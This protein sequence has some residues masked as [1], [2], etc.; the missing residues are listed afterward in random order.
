MNLLERVWITTAEVKVQP[1]DMSSGDC[2][3]FMKIIMWAASQEDFVRKLETYLAR[4]QWVLLSVEDTSVVDSSR[5]Y[6]DEVNQMIEE[7]L[8]DH[9]A[10]RLGTYYSY[11]AN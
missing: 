5:D 7:A 11:K 1:G 2:L 6:G 9:N 3:G 10:I 8:Q 4:Y